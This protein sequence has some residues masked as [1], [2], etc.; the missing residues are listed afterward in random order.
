MKSKL[1]WIPFI[2]FSLAAIALL[3]LEN[4][5]VINLGSNSSSFLVL[6]AILLMF[7]V[8]I[9]F[10]AI[11][12]KTSPVYL[13]SRNIPAAVFSMLAAALVASKSSL[14]AILN[15]QS[16][17][18]DLFG[19][20]ISAF[21]MLAAVGLVIIAL[22]HIQGRNFLPNMSYFFL[23]M[24]VWGG[25]KLISEFLGNRIVSVNAIEPL[26]IFVYSFM[27]IYLFKLSM[28][29]TTVDGKN[30][31]K[32][33]FLYGFPLSGLGLAVGV[34]GICSIITGGFDYSENIE[35]FS[36]LAIALYVIFVNIELTRFAKTK[37]EQIVKYDLDEY[38][39]VESLYGGY[40]INSDDIVVKSDIPNEDYDYSYVG[41]DDNSF[42]RAPESV[43]TDDLDYGYDRENYDYG[44]VVA[45]DVD[46]DGAIYIKREEADLFVG[47][48]TEKNEPEAS[49]EPEKAVEV[50]SEPV[51]DEAPAVEESEPAVPEKKFVAPQEPIIVNHEVSEDEQTMA[52]IDRLI[53]DMNE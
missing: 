19:L 33:M 7:A 6:S 40:G 43:N 10:V 30:P 44:F 5:S 31:V 42:V 27:M 47:D 45:P 24:P 26:T 41:I 46:D 14:N 18:V 21:G 29:I 11:D 35:Q 25:L 4:F 17:A 3:I 49:K 48:A 15:L 9:V 52:K 39:E 16:G 50:V 2:L 20:F 34:K 38:G 36:F 13:I 22:S 8:N 1:C 32:S 28:V 53:A 12:R 23:M 51:Q 37:E